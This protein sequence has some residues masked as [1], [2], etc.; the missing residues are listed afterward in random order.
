MTSYVPEL[1]CV[2]GLAVLLAGIAL[3]SVPLALVT[4]G[5]SLLAFAGLAGQARARG[6]AAAVKPPR[7]ETIP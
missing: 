1:L 7:V 6:A 2:A 3:W 4:C 5:V